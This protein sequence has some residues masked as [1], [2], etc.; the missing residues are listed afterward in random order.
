MRSQWNIAIRKSNC[1]T[2]PW[3]AIAIAMRLQ[4]SWKAA[5]MFC[6]PQSQKAI[7]MHHLQTAKA[8]VTSCELE[9]AT[10]KHLRV[11]QRWQCNSWTCI[12]AS[13]MHSANLKEREW[14]SSRTR[15]SKKDGLPARE[16]DQWRPQFS[17]SNCNAMPWLANV[18]AIRKWATKLCK[19][20]RLAKEQIT[21]SDC[22]GLCELQSDHHRCQSA[23]LMETSQKKSSYE[24]NSTINHLLA[25]VASTRQINVS[26]LTWVTKNSIQ[27]F[28]PYCLP[29]SKVSCNI[30]LIIVP[31]WTIGLL[32]YWQFSRF[33]TKS[34][35]YSQ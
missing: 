35:F 24:T 22:N 11:S 1:N 34:W 30:L 23:A 8:F 33:Y 20:W 21:R 26:V 25:I 28:K 14:Q 16:C 31:Y 19:P 6:L 12:Q 17:K 27:F 13:A 18:I 10:A 2:L 15:K 5:A 7:A 4:S 3:I 29:P 32:N 9:R